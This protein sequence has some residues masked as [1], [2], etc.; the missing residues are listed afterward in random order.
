MTYDLVVLGGGTAGLV[1]ALGSAALGA[2]VVLVERERLGG[3]CLW[4]GCVPSKSLI[5]AAAAAQRARDADRFGIDAPEPAVDFPAVMRHVHRAIA[6]I[7]PHDSAARLRREGVTVVTGH[8]RFAGAERIIVGTAD[9][10]TDLRYRRALIATGSSPALPPVP[11]LADVGP[12]TSDSIWDLAA[13]PTRLVVLGG[14]PIGCELGQAFARLGSRVTLLEVAPRLLQRDHADAAQI[15]RERLEAEGL[16]VHTGAAID[17]VSRR[18]GTIEVRCDG[19]PP[20]HADQVLVAAGR[21][22]RTSDLGLESVGV[23]LTERG[24]VRVNGRLATTTRSIFAAGDVTGAPAFT[25]VAGYHGGL[26]VQN[27]I[28]GLRRTARY[29]AIPAVTYTDPEVAQVGAL[30]SDAGDGARTVRLEH[31]ALDRA[32]AEAD[33]A[34]FTELVADRRG[35]LVGATVVGPSAGETIDELAYHVRAGTR[36]RTLAGVVHAYPTRSEAIQRAALV[37]LRASLGRYA[38]PLRA[39]L[40]VRRRLAR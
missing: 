36:L 35:R 28:L 3:D 22:P 15:V 9:G 7:E 32:I 38:G 37:D 40:A 2:R 29:E 12:L 34:G 6:T 10:T 31:A 8:A 13:L 30:A 19:A 1:A 18:D 26:I 20:I 4:T 25:H 17:G 21:V 33:T 11:G 14:G 16:D 39:Y 5:A 27:A 23:E 24:H